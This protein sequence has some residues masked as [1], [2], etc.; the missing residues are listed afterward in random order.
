MP[1][2]VI[3][4]RRWS[5]GS[6]DLVV[7]GLFLFIIHTIWWVCSYS[8]FF[9]DQKD[10]PLF[11][12]YQVNYTLGHLPNIRI[13]QIDKKCRATMVLYRVLYL[14]ISWWVPKRIKKSQ[15]W[16]S[17]TR[18]P[19]FASSFIDKWIMHM[20]SVHAWID[21]RDKQ[22]IFDAILAVSQIK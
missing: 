16:L 5:V 22:K 14:S 2:I 13:R 19:F 8:I 7:P 3:F 11:L 21:S 9:S 18:I 15:I 20:H 6:D 17:Q 4:Q 12:Y 1:G 10:N